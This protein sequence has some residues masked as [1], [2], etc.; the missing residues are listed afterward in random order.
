[1]KVALVTAS[2][3]GLGAAIAKVLAPDFRVVINYHSS[4]DRAAKVI[5]ELEEIASK[6]ASEQDGD[7][8]RF[9]SIQ[10]DLAKRADIERLVSETVQTMGRL[11][12]LISNGGW[13]QLRDFS[14]FDD[15]VNEDDW[16]RCFNVNVK[17]HLFLLYAA[18]K[19]LEE[20]KGSYVSVASTSGIKPSGSSIPYAVSKAAQIHLI[21]CL[22]RCV[23]PNIRVNSVSP[24]LMLTEWGRRFPEDKINRTKELTP[25]KEL[26]EVDDVAA[27]VRSLA[28]NMS[29]TG[30]NLVVDSGFSV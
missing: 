23:G 29:I 12:V 26:A 28:V 13:T 22:T 7:G 20:A 19:H 21:Q 27:A 1:M 10:A 6:T 14:N 30:Q 15:N 25:L 11:D 18:R 8:P 9:L 4:P 5:A 17:S 24:G 16:D 2:S 3:A